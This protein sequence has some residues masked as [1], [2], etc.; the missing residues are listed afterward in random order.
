MQDNS[1]RHSAWQH[2][3]KNAIHCAGV[4]LHSGVR[5]KMTLHPGAIDSG[6][7]FRLNDGE[8]PGRE[9]AASWR[10]AIET[11]LCTTLCDSGLRIATIEHLLSAFAGSGVDNAVVELDGPEVPIM[12]GSAAP[13]LFL[14][15]CAGTVAQKA[16]RRSLRVLKRVSIEEA[17]RYATLEPADGFTLDFEISFDSRAVGR[18]SWSVELTNDSYRE[19]I[20]RAR[21]FGFLK[22]IDQMRANGLARGGS[23]DNAVVFDGNSVL[24][25]GGLRF[26]NEPVRHKILDS[27]GDLYLAGAPIIGRFTGYCA[28]HALN[29]RLLQALFA[30]SSAWEWAEAETKD[31]CRRGAAVTGMTQAVAVSA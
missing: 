9:V 21:T 12:D 24:N 25:E 16:A 2:T 10:N 26:E 29:L 4:G 27:I 19:Q 20:A 6:I 17:G 31:H 1:S 22:D 18:Q 15:D 13:F 11:P 28:G 8:T 14:I 23:L 5:T 7:V 3:L 30:D